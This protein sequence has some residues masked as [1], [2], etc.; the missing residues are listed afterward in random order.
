MGTRRCG[1]REYKAHESTTP[2]PKFRTG[3]RYVKDKF[4]HRVAILRG[5]TLGNDLGR[6]LLPKWG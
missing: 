1:R 5:S 4:K 6:D 2:F 3:A